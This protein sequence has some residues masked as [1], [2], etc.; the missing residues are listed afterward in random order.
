MNTGPGVAVD[1]RLPNSGGK[2]FG[3]TNMILCM[4]SECIL[5]L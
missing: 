4:S 2:V 3:S 5:Q 1:I